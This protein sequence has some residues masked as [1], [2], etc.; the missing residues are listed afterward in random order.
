M[1]APQSSSSRVRVA[2]QLA[3]GLARHDQLPQAERARVEPAFLRGLG[4]VERVGQRREER[5]RA[6]VAPEL[7]QAR[8][9]AEPDGDHRRAGLLQ[10]VVVD[11]PARVEAVVEAVEKDVVGPRAG[12]PEGAGADARRR[13]QVL[14]GVAEHERLPGRPGGEVDADDVDRVG[15]G[16]VAERRLGLL[17]GAQLLLR[18]QRDAAQVLRAQNL[19]GP[20]ARPRPACAARTASA[21][22]SARPGRRAAPPRAAAS[23]PAAWSPCARR[24]R[25]PTPRRKGTVRPRE[26]QCAARPGWRRRRRR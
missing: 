6:Q 2:R 3:A 25:P 18:R 22:S 8:A 5:R 19:L 14:R 11:E 12:R 26:G 4:E 10:R 21:R 13:R 23:R 1:V 7:E 17:R 20:D 15:A 9:L 24:S 16:E